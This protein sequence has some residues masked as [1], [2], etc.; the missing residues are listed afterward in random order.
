MEISAL[1]NELLTEEE[2][3]AISKIPSINQL[4]IR[5]T[6]VAD[7][8]DTV[9]RRMET[10]GLALM[11]GLAR[12]LKAG[13]ADV[14]GV[15]ELLRR[16]PGAQAATTLEH[17]VLFQQLAESIRDAHQLGERATAGQLLSII[18]A[19]KSK[20]GVTNKKLEQELTRLVELNVGDP[21]KIIMGQHK[22]STPA[23]VLEVDGD[24]VIV[25][26]LD[27]RDEASGIPTTDAVPRA[28]V[29][30]DMDV[31]VSLYAITDA[32]K[33]SKETFVGDS[34]FEQVTRNKHRLVPRAAG[35]FVNFLPSSRCMR[36][37]DASLHHARVE[38]VDW[39]SN[40]FRAYQVDALAN[41][42]PHDEQAKRTYFYTHWPADIKDANL[43]S[44][45]SC[46]K[47]V[48]CG[49]QTFEGLLHMWGEV[50]EVFRDVDGLPDIVK[51]MIVKLKCVEEMHMKHF[52]LHSKLHS[53]V[54]PHCRVHALSCP[55]GDEQASP[56]DPSL[57]MAEDGT[58]PELKPESAHEQHLKDS[59]VSEADTEAGWHERCGILDEDSLELMEAYP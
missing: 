43:Q 17:D 22:K 28:M 31:R 2:L 53:A 52:H 58:C 21:V 9:S 7:L 41:G 46:G 55:Y 45:C 36:V 38:R 6:S 44:E 27:G 4:G 29:I 40:L 8:G 23:E 32:I 37:L 42:I 20:L 1:C 12:R 39:R 19:C 48:Q 54:V 15:L 35:H 14:E 24:D 25:K 10:V 11:R 47:C 34:N 50:A 49:T 16:S 13:E 5:S 26:W 3:T 30:A 18:V 59:G 33:R 56:C 51:N 57:H